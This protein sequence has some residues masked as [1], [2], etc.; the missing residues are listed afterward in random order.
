MI[1]TC[2]WFGCINACREIVKERALFHRERRAGLKPLSYLLSKA[3]VLSMLG[4]L[5]SLILAVAVNIFI[6]LRGPIPLYF[7]VLFLTSLAGTALGLLLSALS[8]SVDKSVG[9][10][11]LLM[12]PQILFSEFVLPEKYQSGF[13]KVMEKFMIVRWGYEGLKTAGAAVMDTPRL[14]GQMAVLLAFF[15]ILLTLTGLLLLKEK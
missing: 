2:V 14:A 8:G 9:F 6:P 3:V 12:I 7:A 1:L 15:L 5:Q 13:T 4:F 10:V 11:P